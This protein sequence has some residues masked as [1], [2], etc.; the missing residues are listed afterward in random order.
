MRIIDFT[1][2]QGWL[3]LYGHRDVEGVVQLWTLPVVGWG[4]IE[5]HDEA[6]DTTARSVVGMVAP[7]MESYELHVANRVR[8]FVDTYLREEEDVEFYRERAEAY[9]RS[10]E[11]AARRWRDHRREHEEG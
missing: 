11:E 6:D 5:R 1:P 7:P 10:E 2:T 4:L 3:A 9:L 8:G